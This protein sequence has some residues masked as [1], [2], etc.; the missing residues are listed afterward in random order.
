MLSQSY[1]ANTAL[2]QISPYN[3]PIEL[4]PASLHPVK[5]IYRTQDEPRSFSAKRSEGDSSILYQAKDSSLL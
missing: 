2:P 4:I 1:E 3:P 5:F